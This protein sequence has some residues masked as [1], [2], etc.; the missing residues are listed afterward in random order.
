MKK[1]L[2]IGAAISGEGVSKLLANRDYE[3]Y[4]TDLK[5]IKEKEELENLGI[6]CFNNGHPDFLKDIDYDLIVKNPGIPYTTDFVRY[7]VDRGY[8]L[9]NEIEVAQYFAP[10]YRI[11]AISGTNGKTTTTTLLGQI[12]KNKDSNNLVA[13]NIG[14]SLCLDVLNDDGKEKLVSLE[15]AAFQ[16]MGTKEFHPEVSVIM[17]LTPDHLDYFK[18]CE[19]Y[20]KAKSLIYRNQNI[21]DYFLRNIDDGNVLEYCTN[22]PCNIIDFSL[23]KECDLRI[24]DNKVY[25]YDEVLFETGDLHIPGKHNLQNAMVA[26]AM[27]YLMGTDKG[28]IQKTIQEFKGVKD[29]IEFVR[30]LNGVKYYNDS[31]GTNTDA[32]ITALKSFDKPIHLLA[33]GYDKHLPFE[34]LKPYLNN[35]RQMYV[36]GDTKYKL[37]ELDPDALVFDNLKEALLAA[38]NNAKEGEIVLLSPS[39]ASWDQYPNY[40]VRGQEFKDIVNSL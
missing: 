12:F 36:F 22:I 5:E 6:K 23:T 16:L 28:I 37:K 31:K 1:A 25:L 34:P 21:D 19:N 35:V 30:E 11:G 27:A 17:N 33:G 18:T 40:E 14:E 8:F 3:V 20:Y 10:L 4:L 32:T 2:V 29:R 7:F 9:Y 26:A 38:Y 13:G 39:C 24:Q 15:I